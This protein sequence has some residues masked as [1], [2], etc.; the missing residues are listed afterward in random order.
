MLKVVAK[1]ALLLGIAGCA[2]PGRTYRVVINP[3]FSYDQQWAIMNAAQEWRDAVGPALVLG[4]E[5]ARCEVS[6]DPEVICVHD[7]VENGH[8]CAWDAQSLGCTVEEDVVLDTLDENSWTLT[9]LAAHEL[10]HAMGLGHMPDP[11]SMMFPTISSCSG[12]VTQ[13]DVWQWWN[14]R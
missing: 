11:C 3:N 10:G 12:T 1:L 7:I 2:N 6:D 13:R 14:V 8:A 5:V 9:H 4:L